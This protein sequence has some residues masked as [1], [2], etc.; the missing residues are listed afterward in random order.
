VIVIA[1]PSTTRFSFS[2]NRGV[3]NVLLLSL[4]GEQNVEN[5]LI[6]FKSVSN[7]RTNAYTKPELER[8]CVS[9]DAES[10]LLLFQLE[11]LF[12]RRLQGFISSSQVVLRFKFKQ[13]HHEGGGD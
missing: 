3:S 9:M 7:H 13:Q 5:A 11:K 8:I 1:P 6:S 4:L 2:T 10:G 12:D